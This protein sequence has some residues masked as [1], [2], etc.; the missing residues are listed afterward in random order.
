MCGCE[1]EIQKKRSAWDIV[2]KRPVSNY[3]PQHCSKTFI[4]KHYAQFCNNDNPSP[5]HPQASPPTYPPIEPEVRNPIRVLGLFD[6]IGTGLLVLK[7]LGIDVDTYIAS[8]I[9]QDAIKVG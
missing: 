3:Q 4:Y 9:D 8:E 5:P 2:G 6:G 1:G 7:E